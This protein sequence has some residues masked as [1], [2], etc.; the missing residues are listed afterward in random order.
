MPIFAEKSNRCVSSRQQQN[1]QFFHPQL[2]A[3]GL[4]P[5]N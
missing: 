4:Y 5:L 3:G 2:A 1:K